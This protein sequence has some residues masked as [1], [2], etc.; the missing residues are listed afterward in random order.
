M[1]ETLKMKR[2]KSIALLCATLLGIIIFCIL[3]VPAEVRPV[4]YVYNQNNQEKIQIYDAGDGN[5]YVFLPAY[6]DIEQMTVSVPQHS[7]MM[8]NNVRI[9]NEMSCRN[10]ALETPYELKVGNETVKLWFYQSKNI[11]ALHID[12][13]TG[14]MDKIHED[15]R[16]EEAVSVSLYTAEGKLDFAQSTA[17]LTGRGNTTWT[18]NKRPYTLKLL[19]DGNLLNMGNAKKWVLLANAA[20]QSHLNN[21][22]VFDLAKRVGMEWSPEG[23]Y[24]DVYFNGEYHGL[25]LLAEKVE[26]SSDR[27][28]IKPNEGEF[29]CEMTS[30]EVEAAK[31]IRTKNGRNCELHNQEMVSAEQMKGMASLVDELESVILS[32]ADL[33]T[34]DLLDLDSWACR[35]I[36]DEI[37]ANVDSDRDSSYFY[38]ADGKFHAGPVWDYDKGFGNCQQSRNPWSFVANNYKRSAYSVLPY[39]HALYHNQSFQKRVREIFHEQFLPVLEEQMNDAID[40]LVEEIQAAERM[41]NLRWENQTPHEQSSALIRTNPETVKSYINARVDFLKSAWIDGKEYCTVQFDMKNGWE[42]VNYAVEKELCLSVSDENINSVDWI[43]TA[44]GEQFDFKQ[45]ITEDLVLTK[46]EE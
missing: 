18:Y 9:D 14:S 21:K 13:E 23:E 28:D 38:F 3:C 10:L 29:L 34:V 19:D 41:D 43:N 11:P 8:L 42:Y 20:D 46:S 2:K 16:Y 17:L 30:G 22:L 40:K 15:K 12:T 36:I 31:L 33:T 39:Y 37:A 27:L 7:Q 4:F 5:N 1:G 24:V 6:A 45:P 26:I 25:Y 35:Y 32:D 44:T